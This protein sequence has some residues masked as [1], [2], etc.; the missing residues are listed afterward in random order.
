MN[1]RAVGKIRE[2]LFEHL[3]VGGIRKRQIRLDALIVESQPR[4]VVARHLD[5]P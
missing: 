1:S 4:P 2:A 3:D 5:V